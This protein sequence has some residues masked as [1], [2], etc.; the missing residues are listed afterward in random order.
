M[1]LERWKGKGGGG[2]GGE[3]GKSCWG[4]HHHLDDKYGESKYFNKKH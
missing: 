2:G 4:F 1:R 3:R